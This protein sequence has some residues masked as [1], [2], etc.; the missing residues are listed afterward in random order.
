MGTATRANTGNAGIYIQTSATDTSG[1][2]ATFAHPLYGGTIKPVENRPAMAH[3]VSDD[4]IPGYYKTGQ[5]WEGDITFPALQKSLP[6]YVGSMLGAFGVSGAGDPYTHTLTQDTTPY[7]VTQFLEAPGSVYRKFAA[8]KFTELGF[9]ASASD[10]ILKVNAK[11]IG[12]TPSDL[13]SGFTISNDETTLAASGPF[14]TF[15]GSTLKFDDDATPASTTVTNIRGFNLRF[16]RGVTLEQTN[17]LNPGTDNNGMF[18]IQG[19]LDTI[20]SSY[21]TFKATFYGTVSGTASSATIVYG[22]II[23]LFQVGPAT[24]AN[25]TLTITCPNLM[26]MVNDPPASDPAGGPLNLPIT[27]AAAKPS[28]GNIATVA[29]LGSI[30]SY[31]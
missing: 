5:W 12:Y 28:S 18:D 13:A 15:L 10:P 21:E 30:S 4:L 25:R 11:S 9:S 22:A 17:T 27:F 23:F 14:F 29:Q 16:L 2:T 3:T 1:T 24:N 31:V 7:Y 6:A 26:F 20:W 8:G 19:E